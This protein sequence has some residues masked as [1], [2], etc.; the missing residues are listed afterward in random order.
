MIELDIIFDT[1][2]EPDAEEIIRRFLQI[3]AIRLSE[4]RGVIELLYARNGRS[5]LVV[6]ERQYIILNTLLLS[7]AMVLIIP[8]RRR[9]S[10]RFPIFQ[11][12]KDK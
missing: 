2:N 3:G 12:K 10:H 1:E 11:F 5:L 4:T 9:L 6:V 7:M 8:E